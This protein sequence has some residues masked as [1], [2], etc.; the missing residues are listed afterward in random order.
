[1]DNIVIGPITNLSY[2]LIPS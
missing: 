2:T 1:M